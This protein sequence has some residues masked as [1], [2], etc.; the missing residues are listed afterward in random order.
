MILPPAPHECEDGREPVSL[1]RRD[2][3]NL[4]SFAIRGLCEMFVECQEQETFRVI[5][6]EDERRS[7]LE[8]IRSSQSVGLE[9]PL[10]SLAY[11]TI[12]RLCR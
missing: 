3:E 10:G 9:K 12:D 7:E 6:D 5:G 1:R 4:E 2:A 11:K 8:R